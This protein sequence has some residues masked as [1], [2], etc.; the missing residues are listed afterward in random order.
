[1]KHVN[2]VWL[3][4]L[5]ST[6][7]TDATVGQANP[8]GD[9]FV[10]DFSRALLK[11]VDATGDG[12]RGIKGPPDP[13]SDGEAWFSTVSLP[14]ARKCVVWIYRDHA[15]GRKYSCDFGRTFDLNE[16]QKTYDQA[17]QVV[18]RA[19]PEWSK[20]ENARQS[21]KTISKAEFSRGSSGASVTLR[22]TE[23]GAHGYLLY[24]DVNPPD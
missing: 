18:R 9:S 10:E 15:L 13:A 5:L 4:L 12:F 24:V 8:T 23:H 16:A 22:L 2:I 1:V 11:V 21:S 6:T 7:S 20:S 3:C 17:L 19:L 14:T